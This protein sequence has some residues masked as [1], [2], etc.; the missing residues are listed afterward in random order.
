MI[1]VL[2]RRQRSINKVCCTLVRNGVL[3][4]QK[5]AVICAFFIVVMAAVLGLL[6]IFG[7]MSFET[8]M[9]NMLKFGGAIALLGIASALIRVMM[10]SK[11]E[12]E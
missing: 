5:I 8:G 11:E 10:G 7:M 6:I 3:P 1:I 4:M 2:N 9:M 12:K